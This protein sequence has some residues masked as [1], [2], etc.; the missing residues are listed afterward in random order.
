MFIRYLV[1]EMT[2]IQRASV[3]FEVFFKI[4]DYKFTNKLIIHADFSF[5]FLAVTFKNLTFENDYFLNRII[6]REFQ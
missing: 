4:H 1:N 6:L 3:Y 2:I 5:T